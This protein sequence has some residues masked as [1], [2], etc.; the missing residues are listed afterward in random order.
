MLFNFD[1]PQEHGLEKIDEG[2]FL[3]RFS[4]HGEIQEDEVALV[5]GKPVECWYR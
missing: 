1:T 2:V 4:T 5:F 3:E